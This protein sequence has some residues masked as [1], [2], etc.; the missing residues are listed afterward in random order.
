MNNLII[1][2]GS[3]SKDREWQITNCLKWL[4]DNLNST[5]H[6]SIYNSAA[7]NGTDPD[8]LNAVMKAKCKES[9]EEINKKLKDYET[10]C[11]RTPLSKQT[12]EIP[13]DLDIIIWNGNIIRERDFNQV[14][15]Q[16]GWRQLE[17]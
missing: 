1:S 17:K 15:F 5:S 13:M 14:Y 10:V 11:G 2:I 4:K 8:Y 16:T 6:S 12:G 9:Y 7:S 3:N